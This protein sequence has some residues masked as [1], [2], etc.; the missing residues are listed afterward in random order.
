YMIRIHR[1]GLN[2]SLN[3]RHG[4]II[5]IHVDKSDIVHEPA[6]SFGNDHVRD[7]KLDCRMFRVYVPTSRLCLNRSWKPRQ[8]SKPQEQPP[9]LSSSLPHESLLLVTGIINQVS[10]SRPT[11]SRAGPIH[12]TCR[13]T[14]FRRIA[15]LATIPGYRF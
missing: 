14:E 12:E 3:R 8:H 4:A 11:S 6:C 7:A 2:R 15:R 13:W 9:K 5:G 1:F 10:A